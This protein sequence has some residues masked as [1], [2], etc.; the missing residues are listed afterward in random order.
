MRQDASGWRFQIRT[1]TATNRTDFWANNGRWE[2]FLTSYDGGRWTPAIPVPNTSTRPD[3]GF[4]LL[5]GLR[6]SLERVGERQPRLRTAVAGSAPV[7]ARSMEIDAASF[8]LPAPA[9]DAALDAFAETPGNAAR[10]IEKETE[11]VAR[12]RTYRASVGGPNCAFCAATFTATPR[13]PATALATA[14]SK[15]TSAT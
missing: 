13:S 1:S 12:I 14:R 3:G 2:H 9:G 8:A 15:T 10:C 11:D 4:E 5:P 6:G 7:P